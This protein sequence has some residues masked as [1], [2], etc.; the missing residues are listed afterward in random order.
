MKTNNNNKIVYKKL[1][2]E[3]LFN[4]F[5]NDYYDKDYASVVELLP[6]ATCFDMEEAYRIL[7]YIVQNN[8]RLVAVYPGIGEEA[9]ENM[10]FIGEIYDGGLYIEYNT[11]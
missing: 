8:A 7:E 10:E 5:I 3:A 9:E 1:K 4:Y 11:I 6:Q 2:G